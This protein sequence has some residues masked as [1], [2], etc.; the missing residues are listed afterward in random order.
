MSQQMRMSFVRG[1]GRLVCRNIASCWTQVR[2]SLDTFE[3]NGCV[4][5]CCT[6]LK[7]GDHVGREWVFYDV[8]G[9]RSLVSTVT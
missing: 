9:S 8:G 7:G 3:E 5:D 2:I 1:Y 6:D 4:I